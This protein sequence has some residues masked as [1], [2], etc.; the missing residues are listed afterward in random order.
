[1]TTDYVF[2][3]GYS[4]TLGKWAH[5]P[6]YRCGRQPE[7]GEVIQ[8]DWL[9]QSVTCAVCHR[10]DQRQLAQALERSIKRHIDD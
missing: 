9:A 10:Q 7:K 5:G 3:S 6:C 4:V 1:M 2:K 8:V